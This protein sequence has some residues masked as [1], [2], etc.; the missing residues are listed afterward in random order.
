M[1]S[2]DLASAPMDW[3]D[4]EHVTCFLCLVRVEQR[5]PVIAQINAVQLRVPEREWSLS[6]VN[7]EDYLST[8]EDRGV[9][10]DRR[11]NNKKTS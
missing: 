11:R 5:G 1:F 4:S 3:G 8:G 10:S 6:L 7:C 2:V 9:Q